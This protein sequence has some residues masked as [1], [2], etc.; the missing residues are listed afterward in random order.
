ML[1]AMPF[2]RSTAGEI[3]AG[4]LAALIRVE[5]FRLA[6]FRKASCSASMQNSASMVIDTRWLRTRRLNQSDHCNEIDKAVR[7]RNVRNI[8][9]PDLIWL[10]HRQI[11]QEIRINLVPWHRLRCIR[12]AIN[13]LDRHAL[14]QRRDVQAS[15]LDAF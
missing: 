4:E 2:L 3:G 11:A 15:G 14:H 6:M 13:R 1:M 7:H 9:C 8:R 5:D 12:L 10:R